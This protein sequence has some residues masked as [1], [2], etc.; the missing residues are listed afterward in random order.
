MAIAHV[1]CLLRDEAG[2][3]RISVSNGLR[4]YQE[5]LDVI[6]EQPELVSAF[7]NAYWGKPGRTEGVAPKNSLDNSLSVKLLGLQYRDWKI[8][9]LDAV[10]SLASR[11]IAEAW[12]VKE[13]LT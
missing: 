9:V 12:D 10:R 8:T 6:H 11:A 1:E 13:S 3:K 5:F 4:C 7:P 2:S